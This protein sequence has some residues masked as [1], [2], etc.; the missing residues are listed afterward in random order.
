MKRIAVF[1]THPIQYFA[2]IWRILASTPGVSVHVYYASDHS[3][4]GAVDEQF[5]LPVKWDV[6]VLTGYPNSFMTRRSPLEKKIRFFEYDRKEVDDVFKDGGFD[7]ALLLAY[8]RWLY[9]RA[10]R[11]ANKAGIPV[12]FR[13]ETTDTTKVKRHPLIKLIRPR[14][15]HHFYTRIAAFLSIGT[16]TTGHYLHHGVEKNRIF[17]SPYS[18]DDQLFE[19]Q[20]AE[21]AHLRNE[22]RKD[23]GFDSDD[24]VF[25]FSGKMIEKKNPLLIADALNRLPNLHGIGFLAV[26]EGK[27]KAEFEHRIRKCLGDKATFTGFINQS[28]LGRY[29][30]AADA[31]VL[32]SVWEET[33]GLVVNEAMIFGLPVIVS[34]SVGC[35]EDLVIPGETGYIFGS[36]DPV[37][38]AE[39]MTKMIED[40][41]HA[42]KM[43]LA[44]RKLIGRYT[45]SEA[46]KGILEALEYVTA[47]RI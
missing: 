25:M 7:A 44:G 20:R 35:R 37:A 10:L 18:V 5:G 22:I 3:V 2:P 39:S 34:D 45:V 29:Y 6:P 15:L 36:G 42:A 46:V 23:L 1:C 40:L 41:D 4:R 8:D 32:P 9:W 38:L 11:A 28:Q 43:G 30:T 47:G 31:F 21:F 13:A 33:W 24:F 17:F 14:V 26:G 19:E 27:L 16:G 12:M